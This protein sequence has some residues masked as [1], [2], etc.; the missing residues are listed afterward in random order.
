MKLNELRVDIMP[1]DE[2]ILGFSNQWYKAAM[3]NA[4]P[5]VRHE[6]IAIRLVSLVYFIATKLEAWLGRGKGDALT[7]R[8][9]EDIINLIDGREELLDEVIIAPASVKNYIGKQLKVLLEDINFEYAVS[10][11]CWNS[12]HREQVIFERIEEMVQGMLD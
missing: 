6:E 5:F 9:I 3:E 7:S 11:Q 4:L 12:P 2:S 10:S 1:D 8:D